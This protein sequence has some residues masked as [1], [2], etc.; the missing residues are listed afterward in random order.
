MRLDRSVSRILGVDGR[1]NSKARSLCHTVGA[2]SKAG[3]VAQAFSQSQANVNSAGAA[4]SI[5]I[6]LSNP[7][8]LTACRF[9]PD[10]WH[11]KHP[12]TPLQALYRL[13]PETETHPVP[14]VTLYA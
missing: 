1:Q 6:R 13:S 10:L 5:D 9:K 12:V 7:L 4:D 2:Y 11:H 3:V 8:H 14:Y